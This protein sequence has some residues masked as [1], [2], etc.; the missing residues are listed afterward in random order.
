MRGPSPRMPRSPLIGGM[1]PPSRSSPSLILATN[2]PSS[3]IITPLEMTISSRP[4]SRTSSREN[5]TS[6]QRL[7]T[8]DS[9]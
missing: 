2:G 3:S 6:P 8:S 7:E 5:L 4:T 1:A 9:R